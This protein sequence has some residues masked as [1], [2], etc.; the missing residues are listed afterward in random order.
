[1]PIPLPAGPAALH[2]PKRRRVFL[3]VVLALSGLISASDRTLARGGQPS[4]PHVQVAFT[5]FDWLHD[6]GTPYLNPSA[7]GLARLTFDADA[8][9]T[10]E[11]NGGAFVNIVVDRPDAV[12]GGWIVQNLYVRYRD[13]TRAQAS[14]PSALFK[15]SQNGTAVASLKFGVTLTS[16]PMATA[17]NVAFDQTAAVERRGYLEGGFGEG[18]SAQ[19]GSDVCVLPFLIGAYVNEAVARPARGRRAAVENAGSILVPENQIESVGEESLGCG[20]GSAVRSIRYLGLVNHFQTEPVDAMYMS[21]RDKMHT[22]DGKKGT[23]FQ[24]YLAGK[25]A[26]GMGITTVDKPFS[27]A[28]D[29]VEDLN[30]GADVEVWIKYPSDGAHV[31]M[32]MSMTQ[33]SDGSFDILYRSDIGQGPPDAQHNEASLSIHVMPD[34]T[35][36][37]DREVKK[38]IVEKYSGSTTRPE[39]S[40]PK[41]KSGSKIS[42]KAAGSNIQ[43]GAM[44]VVDNSEQFSLVLSA[45][46]KK[47]T[48]GKTAVSTPSALT[49]KTIWSD[50]RQHSIV[51]MNPDGT[52]SDPAML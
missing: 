35:V 29:V 2:I 50:G 42:L 34:G 26:Y 45:N 30:A 52:Q 11:S 9:E 3:V 13:A 17:P 15:I 40:A 36:D 1:M 16:E 22:N 14:H 46:G 39:I 25:T 18:D 23:T 5:Q 20:P 41:L 6:D 47:W 33:Y 43:Q 7:V 21:L 49:V 28:A 4:H 12:A 10:L 44:L 38:F 27:A 51:V 37:G 32:V 48:I 31:S 24:D 8:D 19:G